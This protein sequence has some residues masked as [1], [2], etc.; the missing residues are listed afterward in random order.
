MKIA[1]GEFNVKIAPQPLN[2]PVEDAGLSRMTIDKELWGDLTGVGR[3]QMLAS[4][5]DAQGSGAYV[6]IERI[7]GTLGGKTGSFVLVHRGVMTKGMPELQVS[8]VPDSGTGELSG[9]T[10][11]F[12]ILI[13]GKKHSYELEYSLPPTP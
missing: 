12:K 13:E 7:T 9:L 6:A 5:I 8:I 1:K 2:G 10:G 3:G 4:N 11:T